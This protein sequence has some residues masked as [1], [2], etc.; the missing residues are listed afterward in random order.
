MLWT[1]QSFVREAPSTVKLFVRGSR[2][3][4]VACPALSSKNFMALRLARH[5]AL[6]Y[7]VDF[8]S[9]FDDCSSVVHPSSP[10]RSRDC[11]GPAFW[12]AKLSIFPVFSLSSSD[13]NEQESAEFPPKLCF[14]WPSNVFPVYSF[15]HLL[16]LIHSLFWCVIVVAKPI[17][18]SG[19]SRT[20]FLVCQL[21]ILWIFTLQR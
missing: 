14:A 16:H 20:S 13:E 19:S 11:L 1:Q 8:A 12:R 6:S 10:Q 17:P 4:C 21:T 18:I 3:M 5:S 2:D 9:Y 15:I 7:F